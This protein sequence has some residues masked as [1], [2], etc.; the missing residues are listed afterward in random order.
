MHTQKISSRVRLSVLVLT[1]TWWSAC[2]GPQGPAGEQGPAGPAGAQGT[3]GAQGTPGAQGDPGVAGPTG[4]TGPQG[5]TG[6]TGP[7]G[8]AGVSP[9][10]VF[11]VR[12]EVP[13]TLIGTIDSVSIPSSN[14]PVVHFTVKDSFGRGAV[15]L[16]AGSTGTLRFTMAKLI[17][18]SETLGGSTSWVSYI[19]R[20]ATVDAGVFENQDTTERTGTLVDNGD[21]SYVYTF[22]TDVSAARNAATMDAIVYEP[23]L[24]HRVAIQVSGLPT[25]GVARLPP[26]NLWKDF[27]PAGGNVTVTRDIADESSCNG[28]HGHLAVH[29]GGRSDVQFCVTCHTPATTAGGQSVDMKV[30]IHKIHMGKDLPSVVAGGT[31]KIGNTDFSHVG[32][33]QSVSN[34][35]T[36]H[37]GEMGARNRT[38]SGNNWRMVPS[39]AACGSCHDNVNFETGAGH[40]AGVMETDK[41]CTTCHTEANIEAKHAAATRT[42]NNPTGIKDDSGALLSEFTYEIA[43]VTVDGTDHPVVAFRILRDGVPMD[44]TGTALPSGLSSGP[45]FIL[46]YALP[47]DGV[48]T[49]ADYNQAGRAAAQP[50]S[51]S[52]ANLRAGTAGTMTGP[53]GAGYYTVTFTGSNA[54]PSGATLRAVGLQGSFTQTT[55]VAGVSTAF[56]RPTESAVKEVTGDAKRRVVVDNAKCLGCH[57]A[58]QLH[59]GSR[60]NNTAICVM[61]HNPNLSSSGRGADAGAFMADVNNTTVPMPALT[62]IA[63]ATYKLFEPNAVAPPFA[64]MDPLLWPEASNNFKDLIHGIHGS[65][66]RS[67]PYVF[68]RD[69]TTSG[70]FGY[71]WSHVTFPQVNGNCRACHVGTDYQLPLPANVLMSTWRTTTGPTEDRAGVLAARAAVPNVTDVV[72]SP[73]ASACA[74]CHDSWL[75]K[76]H[77]QQNGALI[78][79]TRASYNP[80][81]HIE[82]C[83]LCH[84]PGKVADVEAMHPIL[85]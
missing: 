63:R 83:S 47:Q 15:G 45:S 4:P 72:V 12:V 23:T 79:A 71:D 77:M 5:P 53:D 18:A 25:G 28:C 52:L 84:G 46:A 16:R 36:C 85:K 1:A 31:Y 38:T 76:A 24:T 66:V 75:S 68:V 62:A 43:S 19:N 74:G 42:A 2:S 49:P 21:G 64:A 48:L 22:A 14:K 54:W 61:C 8:D 70:V 60:A 50:L 37:N 51:V 67:E 30:M 35:R 20:A 34:C 33:P 10:S 26:Q 80:S 3:S 56:G 32:P 27:V 11:D 59:G 13:A 82:T 41:P 44:L 58:L 65:A 69:R 7:Q 57:E 81:T 29:G 17:P 40:L 73:T 9:A 55:L 78:S 39:R 6:P